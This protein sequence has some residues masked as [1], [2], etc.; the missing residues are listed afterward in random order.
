[1]NKPTRVVFS[2]LTIWTFVNLVVLFLG[3][4]QDNSSRRQNIQIFYP[5]GGDSGQYYWEDQF[6]NFDDILLKYDFSEFLVYAGSTWLLFL[7]FKF[8]TRK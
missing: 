2:I 1:M 4:T 8:I 6:P 3:F 7:L 5:D